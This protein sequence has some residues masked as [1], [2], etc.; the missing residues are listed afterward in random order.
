MPDSIDASED[1]DNGVEVDSVDANDDMMKLD[2]GES[3][4]P[5]I[6]T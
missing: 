6:C 4:V 3:L 5:C 2:L 1:D